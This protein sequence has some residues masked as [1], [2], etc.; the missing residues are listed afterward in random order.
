MILNPQTKELEIEGFLSYEERTR[1]WTMIRLKREITYAYPSLK[2]RQNKFKYKIKVFFS[3]NAFEEFS[4]KILN[5]E[6]EVPAII[7]FE[8]R[9]EEK[10]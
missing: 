6:I 4:K 9:N 2:D 8:R 3:L 7:Y 1:A 5:K 10:S